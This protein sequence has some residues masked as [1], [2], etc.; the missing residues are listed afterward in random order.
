MARKL[1]L[2]VALISLVSLVQAAPGFGD[3]YNLGDFGL[4]WTEYFGDT[5]YPGS[6]NGQF[7]VS[8]SA[9]TIGPLVN[10]VSGG[11]ASPY[12]V[13]YRTA[14]Q[15]QPDFTIQGYGVPAISSFDT[16]ITITSSWSGYSLQDGTMAMVGTGT[17]SLDGQPF[18]LT[19]TMSDQTPQFFV[20]MG[21]QH[22]G[23][24]SA[25][26]LDYTPAAV[27]APIPGAVWLLGTGLLGLACVGRRRRS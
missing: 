23:T 14:D 17:N 4:S 5:G 16:V 6:A 21:K 15:T 7:E 10:P 2:V 27:P 8:E 20:Q 11:T 26:T 19:G 18:T 9:M 13:V 24:F 1:L 22:H 3:T 12:Q 25:L